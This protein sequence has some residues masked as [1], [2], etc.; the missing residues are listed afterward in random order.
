MSRLQF[1]A[2]VPMKYLGN[3]MMSLAIAGGL[4]ACSKTPSDS[5]TGTAGGSSAS[6]SDSRPAD[7][8][9]DAV[10]SRFKPPP[11]LT[12]SAPRRIASSKDF[13]NQPYTVLKQPQD[14]AQFERIVAH[15]EAGLAN[16]SPTP[17]ADDT[18]IDALLTLARDGKIAAAEIAAEKIADADVRKAV[19]SSLSL[20]YRDLGS[21]SALI[22]SVA[23]VMDKLHPAIAANLMVPALQRP[24]AFDLSAS[25]RLLIARNLH[26]AEVEQRMH[27]IAL[28]HALVAPVSPDVSRSTLFIPEEA[29]QN[30]SDESR[31]DVAFNNF[32]TYAWEQTKR[33]ETQGL[34]ALSPKGEFETAPEFDARKAQHD[35]RV[36]AINQQADRDR[37]WAFRG[38]FK[39]LLAP[40]NWAVQ[41]LRYDADKEAFAVKIVT[42]AKDLLIEAT[43]PC[44]RADAMAL[45][46]AL[47]DA[48]VTPLWHAPLG[49]ELAVTHVGIARGA[50]LIVGALNWKT[51]VSL[52]EKSIDEFRSATAEQDRARK[53]EGER[54]YAQLAEAKRLDREK[55]GPA[56]AAG[57]TLCG[58]EGSARR[59]VAVRSIPNA[60]TPR[61]CEVMGADVRVRDCDAREG[62]DGRE[63]LALRP[64]WQPA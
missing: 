35:Q 56:L 60:P 45:K 39:K 36:K 48:V 62:A 43:I 7:A 64:S 34:P 22:A 54:A 47:S 40:Y 20:V 41:D 58:D 42:N 11:K 38:H 26:P 6:S 44:P 4:A 50:T 27:F 59:Y 29:K 63:H 1:G 13:A 9:V 33:A 53:A 19:G 52:A 32:V 8:R 37:Q 28:T 55:Q 2:R 57:T 17:S 61:G 14:I 24:G 51:G 30:I 18:T 5:S 21:L 16:G 31:S 46:Q 23:A 3:L 49:G 10:L 12:M 25:A 15:V